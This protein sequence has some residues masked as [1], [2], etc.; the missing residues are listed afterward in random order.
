MTT[1]TL[2]RCPTQPPAVPDALLEAWYGSA[3]TADGRLMEH[4]VYVAKRAAAWAWHQR[5]AEVQQAADAEL[6][7]CCLW[8]TWRHSTSSARELREARRPTPPTLRE[9]ALELLR[10][11]EEDGTELTKE[12]LALIGEAVRVTLQDDFLD[13]I[14][15]ELETTTTDTP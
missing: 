13:G 2:P 3:P 7:A 9:Q 6:E 10:R 14:A 8:V 11:A 5:H 12:D 15:A 1:P 4:S